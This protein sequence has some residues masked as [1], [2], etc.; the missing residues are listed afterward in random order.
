M[1][2]LLGMK[3]LCCTVL[4]IFKVPF[5]DPVRYQK[6]FQNKLKVGNLL[7]LIWQQLKVFKSPF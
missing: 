4:Q 7:H 1:Q 6:A 5:K 3:K 2:D